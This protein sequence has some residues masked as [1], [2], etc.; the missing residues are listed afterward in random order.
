[1]SARSAGTPTARS[2]STDGKGR[3]CD[4]V[5]PERFWRSI[6][7]GEFFLHAYDTVSGVRSRIGQHIQFFN[8]RRSHS[9]L[10][11]QTL[12]QVCFNRSPQ[13]LAA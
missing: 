10:Q 5:F 12:D 7:Y 2:I 11:A 13:Q 4:N 3:W 8:I 1:M 6:K 9:G